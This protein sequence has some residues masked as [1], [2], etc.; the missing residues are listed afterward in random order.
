MDAHQ[1]GTSATAG[2]EADFTTIR[3]ERDGAVATIVLN[4]PDVLNA[5]SMRMHQELFRAIALVRDTPGIRVLILTGAGRGFCAGDDMKES[6]PRDGACP[7]EKEVEIVWHN[8]VRELRRLP[9]PVIAAVNGVAVGAGSGLV[10]GCDIRI[11]SENAR[12]GDIF[13]RRGIAGG[14]YLL[15]RAVGVAKALELIFTGDIIDAREATRLGIF[16]TVV[17]AEALRDAA[18]QLARRLADGPAHAM[19]LSK[20]AVEDVVNMDLDEGLRR[21]EAS[22]LESLKSPEVQEGIIAFVDKRAAKF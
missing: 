2:A 20:A 21:E 1:T 5:M 11:A 18:M 15:T 4:R 12:F 22:K 17:R 9:K 6:D 10:L 3:F 16:N 13:I 19:A 14:S 7:P 8:I